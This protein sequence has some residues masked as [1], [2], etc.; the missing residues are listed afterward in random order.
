MLGGLLLMVRQQLN[1]QNQLL[2]RA[3]VG[4]RWGRQPGEQPRLL[5]PEWH[6]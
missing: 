4:F 1:R 5:G 2:G 6:N 3:M